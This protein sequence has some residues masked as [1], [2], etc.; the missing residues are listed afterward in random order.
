MSRDEVRHKA[1]YKTDGGCRTRV[2]DGIWRSIHQVRH[3]AHT[4]G[5]ARRNHTTEQVRLPWVFHRRKVLH[6]TRRD[7]RGEK[8]GNR[9]RATRHSCRPAAVLD[10]HP[11]HQPAVRRRRDE[12]KFDVE[13]VVIRL[14]ELLKPTHD[15][16]CSVRQE[17]MSG[18][19]TQN[20]A[21]RL[22]DVDALDPRLREDD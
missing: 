11:K 14:R 7:S 15:V 18:G 9:L 12:R 6:D 21:R 16:L 3:D 2:H 17:Y 19:Q 13:D 1:R 10:I 5:E 8:A 4:K 20:R 22:G